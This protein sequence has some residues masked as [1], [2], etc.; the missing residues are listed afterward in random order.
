MVLKNVAIP[1]LS[2]TPYVMITENTLVSMFYKNP[3]E[4]GVFMTRICKLTQQDLSKLQSEIEKENKI[5]E[6]VN[7]SKP[8]DVS[9][10]SLSNSS[11]LSSIH[12]PSHYNSRPFM[13]PSFNTT[14]RSSTPLSFTRPAFI[15]PSQQGLHSQRMHMSRFPSPSTS[16]QLNQSSSQRP[17]MHQRDEIYLCH[18]I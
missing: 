16:T 5:A 1:F 15:A 4:Y 17:H 11:L 14:P 10:N 8:N 9:F 12:P 2:K 18:E 13:Q 6:S 7:Q 3:T